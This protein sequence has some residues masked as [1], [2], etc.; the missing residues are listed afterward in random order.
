MRHKKTLEPYLF[1]APSYIVLAL[2]MGYPLVNCVRLAFSNYKLTALDSV[3]F[4]GWNNFR[5]I[6]QDSELGSIAFNTLKFVLITLALQLFFGMAL[7][8]ALKR[9]FKGRGLYQG[10]VFLPWAFSGF[11]VGLIFQFMFN[12]V[13]RTLF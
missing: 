2:F 8:L 9:P 1:M 3:T 6:F 5:R 12:A 10:I 7:A 4:A 11:I 13:F